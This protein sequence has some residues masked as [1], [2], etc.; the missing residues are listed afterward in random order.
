MFIAADRPSNTAPLGAECVSL[1]KELVKIR[2][3]REP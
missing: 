3:D 1:L 2:I